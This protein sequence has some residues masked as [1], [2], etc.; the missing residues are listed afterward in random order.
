MNI[1]QHLHR[2]FCQQEFPNAACPSL[3]TQVRPVLAIGA[4]AELDNNPCHCDTPATQKPYNSHVSFYDGL[5]WRIL[6]AGMGGPGSSGDF[7]IGHKAN[8]V[9]LTIKT[10]TVDVYHRAKLYP[11][12]ILTESWAYGLPRQ[13][14][15]GFNRLRVGTGVSCE[16]KGPGNEYACKDAFIWGGGK[17]QKMGDGGCGGSG[18]F[19]NGS[20]YVTFDTVLLSGG[21]GNRYSPNGASCLPDATCADDTTAEDCATLGGQ[22]TQANH[23]C[24]DTACC[25]TPYADADHDGDVDAGDFAALQRCLTIGGGTVQPECRCHDRD[26]DNDV[27]TTDVELFINCATGP[28]TD[29]TLPGC[30][31]GPL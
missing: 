2:R 26:N 1:W 10:T 30:G 18:W 12:N 6:K 19:T 21:V 22:W 24:A 16:L 13:Y 27:D 20:G 14:F 5:K 9:V 29:Q 28:E 23:T 3:S 7:T 25:P 17:C 4:L 8:T 15:G 31:G 11:G